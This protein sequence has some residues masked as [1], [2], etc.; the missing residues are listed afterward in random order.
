[1]FRVMTVRKFLATA[2]IRKINFNA[3]DDSFGILVILG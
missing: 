3:R 2:F 1:M